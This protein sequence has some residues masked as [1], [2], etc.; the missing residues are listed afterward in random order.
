M[1]KIYFDDTTYIWKTKL[2]LKS[3]K[4]ELLKEVTDFISTYNIKN[5]DNFSYK[6]LD[7]DYPYSI[8]NNSK[9]KLDIIHQL[10]I[11]ECVILYNETDIKYNKIQTDSWINIVRAT[12]PKQP[13]YKNHRKFNTLTYHKHT[14][15]NHHLGLFIPD[16]TYV[17]YI[18]MPDV[19]NG[20]DGV[21]YFKS[22]E[23]KVYSI[24][25]EE[26]DLIIMPA[27]IPHVP[28]DAPESTLDRIVLAGNVGFGFIKNKKSLI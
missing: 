28:N 18:Q 24:K 4:P 15:L 16:Y 2:N 25:P 14:D 6:V 9:F 20:D 26:D 21:L 10:G 19:M 3:Y 13:T 7:F 11:N 12:N 27:D 23:N 22:K 1:E 8:K 5:Y 17:Y